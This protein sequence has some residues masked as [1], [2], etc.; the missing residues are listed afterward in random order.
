MSSSWSLSIQLFSYISRTNHLVHLLSHS[1][2]FGCICFI[3]TPLSSVALLLFPYFPFNL[4]AF[5]KL[6]L[7]SV[8]SLFS[9]CLIFCCLYFSLPPFSEATFIFVGFYLSRSFW[10]TLFPSLFLSD[11]LTIIP[12]ASLLR[13][14]ESLFLQVVNVVQGNERW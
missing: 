7:H 8:A 14:E 1:F 3:L 4:V 9:P 10:V 2:S 12:P 11:Y 13:I 6:L 5:D